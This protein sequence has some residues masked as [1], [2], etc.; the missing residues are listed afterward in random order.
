[1]V[2]SNTQSNSPLYRDADEAL[3]NLTSKLSDSY[4]EALRSV[5]NLINL[6]IVKDRRLVLYLGA[7]CSV[8]VHE[9]PPRG[10]EPVKGR[11]WNGLLEGLFDAVPDK[12]RFLQ[13]L[14]KRAGEKFTLGPRG[15]KFENFFELFDRLQLAWFL[16]HDFDPKTRDEEI[17]KLVEPHPRS[18][19]SSDLY[20][21][22][23]DLPFNDI[24]T[25]NYDSHIMRFLK[26]KGYVELTDPTSNART[27]KGYVEITDSTSIATSS[28]IENCSRIFYLHGRVG[29]SQ[30]VFDRF[31]YAKF[32]T[33]RDGMLDYV[34]FLLRDSHIIYVG[35]GLDDPTFNQMETRLQM[36]HGEDRPQSFAFLK[37]VIDKEREVW[38]KRNLEIIDYSD[39][40][41]TP[42]VISW[43][44]TIQKF[45]RRAEPERP[46]RLRPNA[47]RTRGYWEEALRSYVKGDYESSLVSCRAALASSLFWE[48]ESINNANGCKVLPFERGTKLSEIRIRMA[49]NHYKLSWAG[50]EGSAHTALMNE[51]MQRAERL[52]EEQSQR[53]KLSETEKVTLMALD[54]SLTILR[55]RNSY[56]EGDFESARR[57]YTSVVDKISEDSI[58]PSMD[59]STREAVITKL[60]LAE[61][62]YYAKCQLSRLEYQFIDRASDDRRAGRDQQVRLM[63]SVEKQLQRFSEFL[64]VKEQTCKRFPEWEYFQNSLW[65]IRRISMWTA[66]RQAVRICRDLIPTKKERDLQAKEKITEGLSYLRYECGS[67]C[68]GDDMALDSGTWISSPRWPA[69]RNRYQC[70]GYA[71]KWI[72]GLPDQEGDADILRAYRAIQRTLEQT[73]GR[74]LERQ[75]LVNLLE[76]AR[77]HILTIFGERVRNKGRAHATSAATMGAGLDFLDE[78]FKS[79]KAPDEW[80][81]ALGY[82]LASYLALVAG[83]QL[84]AVL[85]EVKHGKLREFL[86]QDLDSMRDEVERQY[87]SFAEKFGD[88][89]S[90][91]R[92]ISYYRQTFKEVRD[93]LN[94]PY[95]LNAKGT[96]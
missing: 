74:G 93:E 60:R 81:M 54:N 24:V 15:V 28:K 69:L 56:R 75:H 32:L 72:I 25:T 65:T 94:E 29:K 41:D 44:N 83:P 30:V 80:L 77:L 91:D 12:D 18:V 66:G 6:L 10:I 86:S 17:A 4:S 5:R 50:E 39:H 67:E 36:L 38:R 82:R 52:I 42:K 20:D 14:T 13:M 76:A 31:D 37:D 45:I 89:S 7:G 23:L 68:D 88:T 26:K 35:S 55:G 79:L 53:A 11:T 78:A 43:V 96:N 85:S 71:L 64:K 22:V 34:T 84:Q 49:L 40:D 46:K 47:D 1:M 51:N 9:V 33:E 57:A 48:R 70:R 58:M 19:C 63:L 8:T 27:S 2:T 16:T 87:R 95:A 92:R 59:E 90:F 73:T 61:G 62:F 21:A 3:Q